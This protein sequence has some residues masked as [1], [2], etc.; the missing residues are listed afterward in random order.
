MQTLH[1]QNDKNI[2][3]KYTAKLFYFLNTTSSM[4]PPSLGKHSSNLERIGSRKPV[5][6]IARFFAA[7][8]TYSVSH[9]TRHQTTC[10]PVTIKSPRAPG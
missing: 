1:L 6:T 8:C 3:L 9:L 4:W 10:Q 5:Q 7:P 2:I